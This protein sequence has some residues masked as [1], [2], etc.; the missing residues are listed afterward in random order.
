MRG[1]LAVRLEHLQ[2]MCQNRVHQ[3][4][5]HGPNA[6]TYIFHKLLKLKCIL[7]DRGMNFSVGHIRDS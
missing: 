7:V 6:C 2:R 4:R 1:H 3:R 5:L